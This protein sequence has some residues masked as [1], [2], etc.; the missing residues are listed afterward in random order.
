MVDTPMQAEIRRTPAH[1]FPKVALWEA[2]YQE[3]RLHASSKPAQAIL[4]LASHFAHN[5]NGQLFDMDDAAFQQ[6][7]ITDLEA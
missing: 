3:G 6:Q 7:M 1:L 2:A 5:C 4:W